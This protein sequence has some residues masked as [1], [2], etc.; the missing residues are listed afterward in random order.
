MIGS[1]RPFYKSYANLAT[2]LASKLFAV[3]GGPP[4]HL[5][6]TGLNQV[7]GSPLMRGNIRTRMLS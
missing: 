7:K 5:C 4:V 2:G 3:N 1:N 6:Q